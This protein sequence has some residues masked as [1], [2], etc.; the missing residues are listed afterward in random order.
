[1]DDLRQL[2]RQS[3]VDRLGRVEQLTRSIGSGTI[4]DV[5]TLR[6]LARALRDSGA[7]H[8]CPRLTDAAGRVEAATGDRLLTEARHLAHVMREISQSGPRQRVLIVG[9]DPAIRQILQARID[10]DDR[11]V[12]TAAT[13]EVARRLIRGEQPHLIILDVALPDGDGRTLL[14]EIRLDEATSALPVVLIGRPFDPDETARQ[15]MGLL[16]EASTVTACEGR[17]A[18]TSAYRSLLRRGLPITVASL[19]PETHGPGGR[20]SDG[21]DTALAPMV[22]GAVAAVV[23][24]RA[25]V[26]SWDGSDVIVVSQGSPDEL[27]G[28][29]DRVRLRLRNAAHP[30]QEGALASFSAAIVADDGGRG[31]HDTHARAQRFALDFNR[32]GGDRVAIHSDAPANRRVLLAGGDTLTA[33]LI[34]HRLEQEGFEVTHHPDGVSAIE[35]IED[36]AFGMVLLDVQMPGTEG[37]EVLRRVRAMRHLDGTPVVLLAAEGGERDVV[38]GFALGADDYILKPFSPAE[39]AARLTRLTRD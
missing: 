23:G 34:I 6:R 33:A 36:G 27:R 18:L 20:R 38:R 13:I 21:P 11:S 9:G 35:S 14:D 16:A 22:R 28:V 37:F 32:A 2:F 8:D 24:S 15:V 30:F 19:V 7:I 31:L 4:D 1:M 25:T 5:E 10:S 26:G 3:V 39:L 12:D 17:G 29:L